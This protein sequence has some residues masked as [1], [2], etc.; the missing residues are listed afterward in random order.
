[1]DI[2]YD[3]ALIIILSIAILV[4]MAITLGFL[5]KGK[6]L[7][8]Y[9]FA[10]ILFGVYLVFL[11]KFVIFPFTVFADLLDAGS[12]AVTDYINLISFHQFLNGSGADWYQAMGNVMLLFPLGIYVGVMKPK[13][14]FGRVFCVG[15]L[16]SVMIESVQLFLDIVFIYP[17]HFMD[18]TDVILNVS[19]F[20][21][22][23]F[24]SKTAMV[25]N[26]Y[27]RE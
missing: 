21:L 27:N 26:I 7:D 15:L 20:V 19:G 6:K 5:L 24:I 4:V 18:V 14:S 11:I 3:P 10:T 1:M 9:Y 22:A 2:T 8:R 23:Y 13:L 17:N 16:T 25:Q 12:Y